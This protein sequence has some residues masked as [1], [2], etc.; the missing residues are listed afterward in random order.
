[1]KITVTITEPKGDL[2]TLADLPPG[3]LAY[4]QFGASVKGFRWRGEQKDNVYGL[5]GEMT[6][7]PLVVGGRPSAYKVIRVLGG[8]DFNFSEEQHD[9]AGSRVD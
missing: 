8:M 1:M 7:Y 3:T 4:V 2:R 5:S 9:S 6:G